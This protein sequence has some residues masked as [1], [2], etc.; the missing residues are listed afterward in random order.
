M[1]DKFF[2][3]NDT[4]RSND[5]IQLQIHGGQCI[6]SKIEFRDDATGELIFEPLHNKT[7]IAGAG[8][9][10]QKLFNL[11]SSVLDNTPT[12]D[13]VLQLDDA[14][15]MNDYPT[16][17]ITDNG[18]E[19]ANIP[20]E[21]QRVIC[22]WCVGTGGAGR[23]TTNLFDT[24]YASWIQPDVLVP[25]RYPL[26]AVDNVDEN[27]YKG[28][29]TINLSNGSTRVAYYFKSFSNTP[30]LVQNY[31][32]TIENV[33]NTISPNTVYDS[34][35]DQNKAQSFVELHLK[36]TSEDCR[37]FFI[38][39]NGLE[40]SRINQISLVY[41]WT[42]TV[43]RTKLNTSNVQTTRDYDVLQQIRPFSICNIPTQK[44]ED[45]KQSI[46]KIYTLYC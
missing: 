45:R 8:L 30:V 5:N 25:F 38:A 20:D 7:V 46:S 14:A 29:K 37:E 6:T 12:Y 18:Q 16:L 3:I 21:S 22:G 11:D 32:T 19:I 28:K 23:E 24:V 34:S 39:H 2:Y 4:C 36:L 31:K 26:E 43:S 35:T 42:K 41:A 40:Q 15:S 44:L 33:S 10:L 1:I 17:A 9:T 27:I 13:Q